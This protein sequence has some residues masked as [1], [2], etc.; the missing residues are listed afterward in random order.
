MNLFRSFRKCAGY[1]K[2]FCG[3]FED[4]GSKEEEEGDDESFGAGLEPDALVDS[5]RENLSWVEDSPAWL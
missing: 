2:R 4:S 1:G 3:A 5:D